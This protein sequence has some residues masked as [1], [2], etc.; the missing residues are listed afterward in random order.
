MWYAEGIPFCPAT[1]CYYGGAILSC[2]AA[3][4]YYRAKLASNRTFQSGYG[5]PR[6]TGLAPDISERP[7]YRSPGVDDESF[8]TVDDRS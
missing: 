6:E 7:R 1:F 3:F 4:Y 8:D 2:P 5:I